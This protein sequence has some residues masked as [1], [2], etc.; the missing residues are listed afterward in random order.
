MYQN[1]RMNEKVLCHFEPTL[2][3]SSLL[4]LL[5]FLLLLRAARVLWHS[6]E[7]VEEEGTGDVDGNKSPLREDI[8]SIV[9]L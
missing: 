4:D 1:E 3:S 6:A 7:P 9:V 2:K 8:V 5:F